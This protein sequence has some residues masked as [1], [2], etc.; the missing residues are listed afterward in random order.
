MKL[1]LSTPTSREEGERNSFKLY[2]P[3]LL[4]EEGESQE[5]VVKKVG[6]LS[7]AIFSAIVGFF[8]G[9]VSGIFLVAIFSFANSAFPIITPYVDDYSSLINYSLIIFPLSYLILGFAFGAILAFAY[10]LL[11]R[12]FGGIKLYS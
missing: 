10:N 9:L 12:I 2:S 11:A 8:I 7:V 5:V 6:V 4:M 3:N 1:V